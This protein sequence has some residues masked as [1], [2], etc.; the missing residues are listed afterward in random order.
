MVYE[1]G[2]G[3]WVHSKWGKMSEWGHSGNW[4]IRLGKKKDAQ[5]IINQKGEV[6]KG[7]ST[8]NNEC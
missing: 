5:W 1:I 6:A 8:F 7:Q 3:T 4:L 2:T